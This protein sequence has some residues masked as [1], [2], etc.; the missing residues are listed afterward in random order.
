MTEQ[1]T[2]RGYDFH[3]HVDLYPDPLA[4]IAS[5]ERSEI[6]TLAVT[7]TPKA[8]PQNRKWAGHS[9]YV[10]P[11]VGLH[12]EVVAECYQE[13]PLLEECISESRLIGEVGLDGSPQHRKAW[14]WQIEVFTRALTAAQQHG[15]RIV[16]IHSRRAA[17]DVLKCIGQHTT[18]DR[19]LPILHWFSG[20]VAEVRKGIALGCYFSIND[21]SLDHDTGIALIGSVPEDRLLTET[22]GP[23][24][25]HGGRPSEPA[26]VTRTVERLAAARKITVSKIGRVLTA[27]AQRVFAFAGVECGEHDVMDGGSW[28]CNKS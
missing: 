13:L 18:P 15:G 4:M 8:W 22:D 20:S 5:C 12:P 3:C 19:V 11:A 6:V 28:P 9:L 17:R 16:S 10:H 2:A 27:N 23:F 25:S 14:P 1:G 24:T 7:T 26:D 21:R